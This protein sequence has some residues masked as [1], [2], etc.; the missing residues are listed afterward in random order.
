MNRPNI[1]AGSIDPSCLQSSSDCGSMS[2]SRDGAHAFCATGQRRE[3][4]GLRGDDGRCS[5][6]RLRGEGREASQLATPGLARSFWLTL[7]WTG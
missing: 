1:S 4:E 6:G 3:R 2:S 5:A 7:P